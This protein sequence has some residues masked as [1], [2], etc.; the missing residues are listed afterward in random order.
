[1]V[2]GFDGRA[3]ENAQ[4]FGFRVGT[5][6]IGESRIVEYRRGSED[7]ETR[8]DMIAAPETTPRDDTLIKGGTPLAGMVVSNLSPAVAE[9]VGLSAD[10]VG[11]VAT[12]LAAEG[13]AVRF[14]K[15]GDIIRNVN[16]VSVLDTAA[17]RDL[18]KEGSARWLIGIERGGKKLI[19]R[20]RG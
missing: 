13:P 12:A 14:F 11:I 4:E 20:L 18:L 7:L 17:L 1:V 10:E 15:K 6:K 2:V 8:L 9:E 5:V 19:I 16:G 3:L